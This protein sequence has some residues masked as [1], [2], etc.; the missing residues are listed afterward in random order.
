[1]LKPF[2]ALLAVVFELQGKFE[3]YCS[4]QG[5]K[6]SWWNWPCCISC[7]AI[8]LWRSMYLSSS[9]CLSIS[10]SSDVS[11]EAKSDDLVVNCALSVK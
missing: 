6:N 1:M 5:Q 2:E 8:S 3:Q 10:S 11:E 9:H 4:L 7:S